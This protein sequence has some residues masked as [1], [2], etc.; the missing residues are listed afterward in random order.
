MVR[1]GS[2]K[3]TDTKDLC[4]ELIGL[5][6]QNLL[7]SLGSIVNSIGGTYMGEVGAGLNVPI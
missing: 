5:G 6:A 4:S 1:F 3:R 2:K 7:T